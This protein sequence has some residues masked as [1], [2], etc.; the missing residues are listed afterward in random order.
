MSRLMTIQ[1]MGAIGSRIDGSA[2]TGP[3]PVRWCWGGASSSEQSGAFVE[4]NWIR[5]Y[6]C[7]K[8]SFALI[9]LNHGYSEDFS[10][11]RNVSD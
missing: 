7:D 4:L 6:L 10:D 8:E 11:T 9:A 2:G 5:R 1:V 3:A